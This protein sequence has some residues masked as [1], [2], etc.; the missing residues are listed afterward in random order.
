VHWAGPYIEVFLQGGRI[1]FVVSPAYDRRMTA[2][3]LFNGFHCP[4]GTAPS[5]SGCVPPPP[6][7]RCTYHADMQLY[8]PGSKHTLA[9]VH[10]ADEAACC[11]QCMESAACFGAELY[12]ESC[13]LKTAQL[14]LVNQTPP[15]GVLLV[16]CVKNHSVGHARD[17][18]YK[19]PSA[20]PPA[21]IVANVTA[22]GMGCGWASSLPRPRR[23][24]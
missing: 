10:A 12:G 9:P 8:D 14:P 11:V 20:L 21:E 19:A 6:K 7:P 24:P 16:A 2:V 18:N 15:K 1:A 17:A 3:R 23:A 13:Y 4:A 5:V 22:H